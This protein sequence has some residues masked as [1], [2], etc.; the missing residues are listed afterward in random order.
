MKARGGVSNP[1]PLV[2]HTILERAEV[3]HYSHI[4]SW[5]P[6]GRSFQVH[7]RDRFTTEILSL[8][9]RQTQ[10]ASFQRQL[11]LYSF[12][13]LWRSGPDNGSYYHEL[14]LRGRPD[15][16]EHIY[17]SQVNGNEVR[18]SSS[19]TTE[20]DFYT[21]PPAGPS[22]AKTTNH[23]VPQ[24]AALNQAALSQAPLQL[25]QATQAAG[26]AMV[27]MNGDGTV[28]EVSASSVQ[29]PPTAMILCPP[30]LPPQAVAMALPQQ[31][32][33]FANVQ[34][35]ILKIYSNQLLLQSFAGAFLCQ[36]GMPLRNEEQ[37]QTA[38]SANGD[39]QEQQEAAASFQNPK[40]FASYHTSVENKNLAQDLAEVAD[41]VHFLRDVDL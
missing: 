31:I 9:S 28:P 15:L 5:K 20:P 27:P 33:G 6:H 37:A 10:F 30:E 26:A 16:C 14:F 35:E 12:R 36:A 22:S 41:M 7:D 18:L 17:R 19:P 24:H 3:D 8:Y 34:E 11:N 25:N 40:I 39:Q 4:V 1:F 13:R 38:V 32:A 29:Y 2:L 21:M 23:A